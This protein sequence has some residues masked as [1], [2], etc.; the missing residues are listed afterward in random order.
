MKSM[1]KDLAEAPSVEPAVPGLV[2]I[3]SPC[4]GTGGITACITTTTVRL[5]DA[6]ATTPAQPYSV[7]QTV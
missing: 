3:F 2:Y 5:F 1:V 7:C 6:A 4:S